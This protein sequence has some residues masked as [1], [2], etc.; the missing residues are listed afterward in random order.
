MATLTIRNVD[1]TLKARL[2]VRASQHG[3][4]MEAEVRNILKTALLSREMTPPTNLFEALQAR[5]AAFGGV[6]LKLS[7]REKRT[8]RPISC[9]SARH[10]R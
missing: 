2:R 9:D 6:E 10:Q 8:S 1:E 3:H 7:P 4:S 5:V